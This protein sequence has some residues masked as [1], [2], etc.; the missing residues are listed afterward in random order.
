MS[1]LADVQRA[2]GYL[3]C[4]MKPLLRTFA[5][6]SAGV[7]IATILPVYPW[8]SQ[9]RS[10][11]TGHAGDV[12]TYAWEWEWC[13]ALPDRARY[14]DRPVLPLLLDAVV[15]VA[16]AALVASV[17]YRALGRYLNRPR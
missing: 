6:V 10:Q 14:V 1:V 13:F 16:I 5:S 7:G 15:F 9:T 8:K 12:I 2:A 4:Q 3:V 17:A 11:V